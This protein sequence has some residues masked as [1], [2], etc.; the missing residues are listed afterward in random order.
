MRVAL[1]LARALGMT[2]EEMF[3][4]AVAA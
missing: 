4:P 2:V 3:G 1:A